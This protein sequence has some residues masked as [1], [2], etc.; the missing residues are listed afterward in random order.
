MAT[1]IYDGPSLL[2]HKTPIVVLVPKGKST[3]RK[4]G[5]MLQTYILLRDIP[6]VDAVKQNLDDAICGECIHRGN[7]FKQ[8]SCYVNVAQGPRSVWASTRELCTDIAAL[9]RDRHV[10]LG[11]YGDPAAVPFEV[12]DE[13]TRESQGW[14]GYTHQWTWCDSRLKK[15][16]MASVEDTS[17]MF[18]ARSM[19]WRTFRAGP[20][21]DDKHP[22][23]EALCPASKE[24]GRKLTCQQCQACRGSNQLRGGIFIP[25]HGLVHSIQAFSTKVAAPNPQ[26]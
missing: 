12:W 1:V 10:R 4:T 17:S 24:A 25:V 22:M 2:D 16:C 9:G 11:T 8:R 3:N 5:D 13:L 21:L 26:P 23:L 6:P 20:S 7:G 18:L 14:T 19:S 15:F